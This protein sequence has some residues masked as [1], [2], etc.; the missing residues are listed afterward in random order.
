[1]RNTGDFKYKEI[2]VFAILLVLFSSGMVFY[3]NYKLNIVNNQIQTAQKNIK[4]MI[5]ENNQKISKEI[6]NFNKEVDDG[7]S[8]IRN[9][10]T[11]ELNTLKKDYTASQERNKMEIKT[12]NSLINEIESQSNIKLDEIKDEL[13]NVK[14]KSSDFSHIIDDAVQSVVRISTDQG[15][16]S[17][18]VI[19]KNGYIV[20]NYHVVDG[21]NKITVL[22]YDRDYLNAKLIGYDKKID[23]A[24]IKVNKTMKHFKFADSDNIKVGQRVIAIGNPAGLSFSVTEGII[25]SVHRTGSNKL[26]I[27]LQ[28]D[29]PINPGN[30]GGPLVDSSGRIVGIN[31]YKIRD[32]EGLGF[33][34]ESNAVKSQFSTI[35]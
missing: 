19:D 4:D 31:N 30:S 7:F 21:T 32:M 28:I 20:T 25:S 26:S 5:N 12:I 3:F 18:A 1:M 13:K 9:D 33:A 17:G 29:V 16:G 11:G 35:L 34:I 15:Q 8:A 23:I 10:F 6:D 14:V 22:T 24:V 27:Y 2:I